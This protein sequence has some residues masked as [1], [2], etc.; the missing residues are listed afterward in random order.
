[1]VIKCSKSFLTQESWRSAF[2]TRVLSRDQ[3]NSAASYKVLQ[4]VPETL[5]IFAWEN[6]SAKPS[7]RGLYSSFLYVSMKMLFFL[8]H[9][10]MGLSGI[11]VSAVFQAWEIDA[12]QLNLRLRSLLGNPVS[13]VSRIGTAQIKIS[14]G[15]WPPVYSWHIRS[16]SA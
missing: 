15:V 1:M 6:I 16:A 10:W 2:E 9:F 8:S 14:A 4:Q 13:Y 7:L 5:L 3:D 12:V 11:Q